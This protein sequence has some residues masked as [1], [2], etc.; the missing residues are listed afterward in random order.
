MILLSERSKNYKFLRFAK[1]LSIVD[2]PHDATTS[3]VML[4][5]SWPYKIIFVAFKGIEICNSV[6]C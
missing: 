1:L 2:R 4:D 6:I 5:Q 3:F